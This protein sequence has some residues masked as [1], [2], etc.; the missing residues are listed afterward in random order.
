MARNPM[1]GQ[2][3]S[4]EV[5]GSAYVTV[6]MSGMGSAGNR[7]CV[8]PIDGRV[9]AMYFMCT[10]GVTTAA[11][12]ITVKDG[13]GDTIGTGTIPVTS[14]NGGVVVATGMHTDADSD[15]SAG[16]VIE[17]EFDGSSGAGAGDMVVQFV[18]SF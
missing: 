4:D 3:K 16:D 14:A 10:T 2:N 1:Y 15:L 17:I 6:G 7:Y 9:S 5:S 8:C 11:S 13:A 12:A 18:Q